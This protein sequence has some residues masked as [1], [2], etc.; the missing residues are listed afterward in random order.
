METKLELEK[1]DKLKKSLEIALP[2]QDLTKK[3]S[4]LTEFMSSL[5]APST[6][7][8]QYKVYSKRDLDRHN[9]RRRESLIE[10]MTVQDNVSTLIEQIDKRINSRRVN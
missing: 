1:E 6:L 8:K 10:K 3:V 7:G 5:K 4:S 2:E 9:K